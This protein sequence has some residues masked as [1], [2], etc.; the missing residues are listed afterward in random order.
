MFSEAALFSESYHCDAVADGE[1]E[2]EIHPKDA[3]FQA[4]AGDLGASRSFMEHLARL[5]IELRSRL[6]I[7][8]I[9]SANERVM[10]FLRLAASELDW[11]VTF[12]RPL[13]DIAG[14]SFGKL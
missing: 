12:A 5:V 13:K 11:S 6:E 10:Q 14:L 7:R 1:S 8:N 9:C 2:I 3:L 4:L